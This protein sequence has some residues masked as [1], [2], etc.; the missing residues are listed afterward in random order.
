M[1]DKVI[2]LG[3]AARPWSRKTVQALGAWHVEL[4]CALDTVGLKAADAPCYEDFEAGGALEGRLR[5]LCE[6]CAV[7]LSA[8]A[9]AVTKMH[10]WLRLTRT[11]VNAI[12]ACVA[13]PG[14]YESFYRKR[15]SAQ[16][17]QFIEALSNKSPARGSLFRDL[18]PLVVK[19]DLVAQTA[20]VLTWARVRQLATERGS[21]P[22]S[23]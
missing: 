8:H 14:S 13:D 1:T 15:L 4:L 2:R 16:E 9:P 10:L 23:S 3:Q 21:L 19:E 6:L 22:V 12:R 20:K 7:E 17:H 5:H 18:Q 11:H